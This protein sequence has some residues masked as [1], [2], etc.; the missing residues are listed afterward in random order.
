MPPAKQCS[1]PPIKHGQNQGKEWSR[2]PCVDKATRTTGTR[3]LGGLGPV[4]SL[5]FAEDHIRARK[6]G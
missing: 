5:T 2:A 6:S 4:A 3:L 1:Q